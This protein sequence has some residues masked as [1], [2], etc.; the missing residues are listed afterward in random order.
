MLLRYQH[1]FFAHQKAYQQFFLIIP[2]SSIRISNVFK[3]FGSIPL[4]SF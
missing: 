2:L 3:V 1:V 4:L